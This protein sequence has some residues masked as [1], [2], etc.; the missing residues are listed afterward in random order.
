MELVPVKKESDDEDVEK[1]IKFTDR[2]VLGQIFKVVWE[3]K[4]TFLWG[5]FCSIVNKVFDV[6]PPIVT[7]IIVDIVEGTPPKW[8]ETFG[9][10]EDP[11]H[12]ALLIGG[13]GVFIHVFESL[14]QYFYEVA[15]KSV[16]QITQHRVRCDVYD[17]IQ[18]KEMKFFSE[19]RLGGTL[20]MLNDDVNQLE[21]FLNEGFNEILQMIV[22]FLFTV[23]YLMVESWRLA[24]LGMSPMPLLII[25]TFYYHR[26][27]APKYAKVR[28]EVGNLAARLENNISGM[29]VIRSFNAEDIES[30]R[31][32]AASD[33]YSKA[34]IDAIQLSSAFVPLIRCFVATG[35]SLGLAFGSYW[36]MRNEHDI[37]TAKLVVFAMLIQRVLWPLV[38]LGRIVDEFERSLAAAKRTFSLLETPPTIIDPD[39]PQTVS[40]SKNE[41]ISVSFKDVTFQYAPDLPKTVNGLTLDIEPG[42]FLGVAGASGGGKSTLIKL[43]LRLW[44]PNSGSV[45]V[46]G[47]NIKDLTLQDLRSQIAL[48]SQDVYLFHGNVRENIA[49]GK[50]DATEEEIRRAAELAHFSEEI[51]R[52]PKGYDT[53]IGERGVKLSGGQRQ[54]LSI[55]RAILKNAPILIMDE[56]TS[57]VDTYTELLIQQNLA[58]LIA[59]KTAIVIAH[60]LSTIKAADRIIVLKDG[61]VH[62]SGTHDELVKNNKVYSMLWGLQ[63]GESELLKTNVVAHEV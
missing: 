39:T 49:Y 2:E 23:P 40:K 41:H 53:L 22:L 15:F 14:F 59:G 27:I 7:G 16:A 46:N 42:E 54:R 25:G 24:L 31:V 55:A 61:E 10:P 20:A 19:H 56:A 29:L 3:M 33:A 30:Q 62:E 5:V 32:S 47:T 34:N 57:S 43:L 28:E 48:V 9:D 44:D 26:L 51:L 35:F 1:D 11:T 37:T 38:R 21:R 58:T 17:H 60:R 13:L 6:L 18:K 36:A 52:L 12:M 4:Y 45:S 50:P 8:V 63:T